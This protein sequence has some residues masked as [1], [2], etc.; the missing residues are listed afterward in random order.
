MERYSV[1]HDFMTPLW[2]FIDSFRSLKGQH[3]WSVAKNGDVSHAFVSLDQ[4]ARED[5]EARIGYPLERRHF[6]S[7]C[8]TLIFQ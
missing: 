2:P 1:V 6:C 8:E 7:A 4:E 5:F 3:T